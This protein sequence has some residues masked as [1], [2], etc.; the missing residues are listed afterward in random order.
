[1]QIQLQL[2]SKM[3]NDMSL[4]QITF[5]HFLLKDLVPCPLVKAL[6]IALPIIF[7]I[8][9]KY[10][11]EDNISWQ[12]EYLGYVTKH[13]LSQKTFDFLMSKISNNCDQLQCKMVKSVLHNLYHKDYSTEKYVDLINRCLHNLI[14]N[15]EFSTNISEIEI[16]L[17][18]MINKYLTESE[19]FYNEQFINSILE[20]LI[21]KNTSFEN[22][23]HVI[24]KLNKIVSNYF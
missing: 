18:R 16:L 21:E 19:M 1:M 7:E 9:V 8:Q 3:I 20:H 4:Q 14:K 13:R 12:I 11:L 5:L 23:C 24:K 17:K 6:K 2:I 15:E 22:V 10:K